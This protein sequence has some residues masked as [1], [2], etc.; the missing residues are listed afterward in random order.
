MGF[1][2]GE[3][4]Y[5]VCVCPVTLMGEL[6]RSK[7]RLC[8]PPGL[9]AAVLVGGTAGDGWAKARVRYECLLCS[10]VVTA[11]S[12][13]GAEGRASPKV[14]EQQPSGSSLGWFFPL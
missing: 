3:H 8:F 5:A 4:L 9:L 1:L 11:P 14:P 12:Y 7:L 10:V 2:V 13:A 6:I